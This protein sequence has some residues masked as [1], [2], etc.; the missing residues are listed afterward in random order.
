MEDYESI[1]APLVKYMKSFDIKTTSD[2]TVLSMYIKTPNVF[3]K[4]KRVYF[5]INQD[6]AV[7]ITETLRTNSEV[8]LNLDVLKIVMSKVYDHYF[9]LAETTFKD[10]YFVVTIMKGDSGWSSP[11]VS[12]S[13][14][15]DPQDI[16]GTVIRK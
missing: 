6:P 14:S 13:V 3:Y 11:V 4:T 1:L 5:R 9:E 2:S 7:D 16:N 12:G 8:T 10:P 15:P